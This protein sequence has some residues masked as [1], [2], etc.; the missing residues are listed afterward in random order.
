MVAGVVWATRKAANR[1]VDCLTTETELFT[2]R[3]CAGEA[4]AMTKPKRVVSRTRREN[5]P[6]SLPAHLSGN[7]LPGA[8]G[9]RTRRTRN[10][11]LEDRYGF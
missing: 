5:T 7:V 11:G 4:N 1:P 6:V 10:T 3:T 8:E 2:A 9:H